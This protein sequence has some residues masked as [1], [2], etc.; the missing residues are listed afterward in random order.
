MSSATDVRLG[1]I[2]L[3]SMGLGMAS[4]IQKYLRENK[5][6]GLHYSNRTLSRGEPLDEL[7]ASACLSI[8]ELVGKSDV[9]FVSVRSSLCCGQP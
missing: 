6:P 5:L 3:G 1:W 8:A 2:G 7:G 4:N 9:I